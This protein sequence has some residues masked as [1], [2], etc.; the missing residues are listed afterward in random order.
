MPPK[1]VKGA[2]AKKQQGGKAKS[3]G[4]GNRRNNPKAFGAASGTKAQARNAYR[5]LEKQERKYH[6]SLTDRSVEVEVTPP[7]VVAVVGPPGVGKSTLIRSLVKHWT[8]QNLNDPVGPVTIITGKKRRITVVECP[9]DLN[10]MCDIAKVADLV[11]LMVDGAFGFEMETFE[12]LNMCQVHGFPRVMGVLTHLDSF[13]NPTTLR[14]TKKT[15]KHRF[16]TDIYEGCKLFYLSGLKH[17]RY[18]KT[19]V[20][21]LARFIAVLKF[22]PLIWRNSHP[23]VLADRM[24]DVTPPAV[25]EQPAGGARDLPLRLRARHLPQAGPEG[26][27]ARDG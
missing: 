5:T 14:R 27:C 17:G 9:N 8:K 2:K 13:T 21:N 12:F 16:W 3:R 4:V 25:I 18:P 15:M 24:E 20:A 26:A 22:R 11:L 1:K 7:F 19:E 6:I 10:A 23:S